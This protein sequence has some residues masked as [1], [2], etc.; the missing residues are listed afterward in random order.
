[1]KA[2]EREVIVNR[3]LASSFELEMPMVSVSTFSFMT[4]AHEYIP[5]NE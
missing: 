5:E 1:M 3:F 2:K 4:R